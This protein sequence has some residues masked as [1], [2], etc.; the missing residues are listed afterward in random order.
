M[1]T[2]NLPCHDCHRR[3]AVPSNAARGYGNPPEYAYRCPD[4]L[5]QWIQQA[6]IAT[7]IAKTRSELRVWQMLQQTHQPPP[8]HETPKNR[9]DQPRA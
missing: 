6:I 1:R 4:C 9:T 2:V 7:M 8:S 5:R 3:F